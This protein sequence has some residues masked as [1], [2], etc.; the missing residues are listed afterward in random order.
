MLKNACGGARGLNRMAVLERLLTNS[1]L[2]NSSTESLNRPEL[3]DYAG[4]ALNMIKDFDTFLGTRSAI[5]HRRRSLR[6]L[7]NEVFSRTF[8]EE[9]KETTRQYRFSW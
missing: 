3:F 6:S 7:C 5:N 2:K 1:L 9:G 8:Y 4:R